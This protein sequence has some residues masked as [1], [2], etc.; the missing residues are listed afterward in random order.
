MEVFQYQT[1]AVN[2]M[3]RE[4]LEDPYG[5]SFLFLIYLEEGAAFRG[6]FLSPYLKPSEWVPF[7]SFQEFLESADHL[8]RQT[9]RRDVREE[10]VRC[11]RQ[12]IA[13]GLPMQPDYVLCC[14][15]TLD[16]DWTGRYI[17]KSESQIYCFDGKSQLEKRMNDHKKWWG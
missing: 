4:S 9:L 5:R 17:R 11:C 1:D 13:K 7:D 10:A 3:I 8:I 14:T 16:G 12:W 2:Y 6:K 15:K